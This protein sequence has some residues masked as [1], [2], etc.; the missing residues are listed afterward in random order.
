MTLEWI[1]GAEGGSQGLSV[2]QPHTGNLITVKAHRTLGSD[3]V[4]SSE[5]R[6]RFR[7]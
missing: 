3:P 5:G 6:G 2:S 1:L 7:G 4:G